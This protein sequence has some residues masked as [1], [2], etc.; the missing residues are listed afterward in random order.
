MLATN[1]LYV[2]GRL[3]M[4]QRIPSET[5]CIITTNITCMTI[6]MAV[7]YVPLCATLAHHQDV[8][9]KV[10]NESQL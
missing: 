1:S 6:G 5:L 8:Q 10:Y 2:Y 3:H 4:Y 7:T 9:V